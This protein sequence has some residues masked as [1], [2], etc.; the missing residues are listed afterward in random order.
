MASNS[1]A[2]DT[3]MPAPASVSAPAGRDAPSRHHP[4]R[5]P[6]PRTPISRRC[7]SGGGKDG[8][9]PIP[10]VAGVASGCDGLWASM[11]PVLPAGW[12]ATGRRCFGGR[13]RQCATGRGVV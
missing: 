10:A 3:S 7:R 12:R 5:W 2:T 4:P 6:S 11:V 13:R 8:A 1:A 9:A